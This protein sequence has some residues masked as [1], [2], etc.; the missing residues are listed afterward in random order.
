[1]HKKHLAFVV[2]GIMALLLLTTNV[3]SVQRGGETG[4][5]EIQR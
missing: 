5:S 1:M 3:V 4:Q 2:V